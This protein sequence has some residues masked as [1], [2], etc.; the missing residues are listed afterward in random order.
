[1]SFH[2]L[3]LKVS[4]KTFLDRGVISCSK[5]LDQAICLTWNHFTWPIFHFYIF[6]NGVLF[7]HT[8]DPFSRVMTLDR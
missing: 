3:S 2:R 7:K 5:S 8:G 6:F 4:E 1:M